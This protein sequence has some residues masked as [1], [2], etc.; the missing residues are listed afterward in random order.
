MHSEA[1]RPRSADSPNGTVKETPDGLTSK[2]MAYDTPPPEIR[3]CR[4]CG[5][6]LSLNFFGLD[7]NEC[8]R[9][10]AKL[11]LEQEKPLEQLA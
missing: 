4:S 11:K 3:Q 2:T 7:S 1:C 8:R 10:E 5:K 6:T 9:C